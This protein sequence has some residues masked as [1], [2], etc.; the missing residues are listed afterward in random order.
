MVNPSHLLW[1]GIDWGDK[2]HAL[3][4]VDAQGHVVARHRIEHSAEGLDLLVA[5]LAS[6]GPVGGVAIERNQHLVIDKLLEAAHTVY[7][8]NPKVSKSWRECLRV[9]PPKPLFGL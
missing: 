1:A 3:T 4:V 6:A 9:D 2:A 7:P 5:I 8:V